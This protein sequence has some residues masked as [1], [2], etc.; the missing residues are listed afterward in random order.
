MKKTI[1]IS[2]L[3]GVLLTI[4]SLHAYNVYTLKK[5]VNIQ[6]QTLLQ[7]VDFINKNTQK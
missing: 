6:G 1:I 3:A 5:Q 2:V 7:I 4:F